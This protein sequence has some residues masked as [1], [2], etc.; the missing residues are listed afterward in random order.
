MSPLRP[1]IDFLQWTPKWTGEL[2]VGV[3]LFFALGFVW[4]ALG[5]FPD[6][7]PN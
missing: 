5:G 2:P 3:A 6:I 1:L 7:T 4:W